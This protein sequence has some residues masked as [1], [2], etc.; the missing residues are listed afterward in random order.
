MFQAP[1]KT[2]VQSAL[3]Q[4]LDINQRYLVRLVNLIDEGV[5][6][7]YDPVKDKEP[8][9]S[10]KWIF[11]VAN[12]DKTPVL[13]IDNT[14]YE[15]WEWTTS[16][17]GKDPSGKRQTATARLYAEALMGRPVEDEEMVR[18]DFNQ[19]LLNKVAVCLFDEKKGS[20]I[21]ASGME[22]ESVRVKILRLTPWQE[23]APASTPAPAPAP[24]SPM[25]QSVAV[26]AAPA[27]APAPQQ[28]VPW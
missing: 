20:Y 12:A 1:S 7:Y 14:V 13:T 26:A 10:I 3:A 17:I 27:A 6:R 15:H 5:S 23:Q 19:Q 21:D 25:P 4:P 22:Q 16:K 9:N 11:R 8:Y 24:A 18:P 2:T 28:D